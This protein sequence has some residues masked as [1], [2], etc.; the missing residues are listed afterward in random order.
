MLKQRLRGFDLPTFATV[1]ALAGVGLLFIYSASSYSA[2]LEFSDAAYYLKKQAI[3]MAF[4]IPLALC[5]SYINLELVKKLAPYIFLVGILLL[6]LVFVPGLGMESY[7]AT[8]WLNLGVFTVQP[9]EIAK[10]ALVVFLAAYMSEYAVDSFVKTLPA[11]FAGLAVC[12][13]II[14]EPN[15]SITVCV[16]AIT[17]IMLVVGGLRAKHALLYAVPVAAAVPALIF[18]EPYRVKRIIAFLDP[19]SSPKAEGYQLIQ[20]FYALA[21]GG[22]FGVGIGNSRQKYLFL[23]FAE[24]DFILSVITEEAGVFGAALV[25]L[26]FL[27]LIIRAVKTAIR[28]RNRFEC[29]LAAGVAAMTA[30]QT[31]VNVAVV[32]GAIPP[33]GLPLPFISAGGTSLIAY[34][35]AFG[36][37]MNVHRNSLHTQKF[38]LP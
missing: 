24:S 8:R 19:W 1:L 35:C 6:G 29:Y 22:L 32:S 20:S 38:M 28:A 34:M 33:T 36:L 5:V 37:V 17:A 4:G 10:F 25:L 3:A 23:P 9:S 12:V 16:A 15:M 11:V 13:L 21:S 27:F 26:L 30:V 31:A 18:S 2:E 7:G 14:L